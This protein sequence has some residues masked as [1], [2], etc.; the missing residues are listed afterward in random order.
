MKSFAKHRQECFK[1][2]RDE[3]ILPE[4]WP[5]ARIYG[6]ADIS[7]IKIPN[8]DLMGAFW[9]QTQQLSLLGL[10]SSREWGACPIAP[11]ET[12]IAGKF[13]ISLIWLVSFQ[14]ECFKKEFLQE[15]SF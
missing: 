13:I 4:D 2:L 10:H 12:E 3:G 5:E 14:T 15:R 1:V 7:F 11:L 9:A 8:L 6:L